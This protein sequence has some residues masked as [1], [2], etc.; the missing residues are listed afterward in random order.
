MY[1]YHCKKCGHTVFCGT[2]EQYRAARRQHRALRSVKN[3]DGTVSRVRWCRLVR[4][5]MKR[6]DTPVLVR[7]SLA[8]AAP[9]IVSRIVGRI[10]SAVASLAA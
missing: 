10:G 4:V 3:G 9:G 8:A 2:K 5:V 6:G 7:P 1:A